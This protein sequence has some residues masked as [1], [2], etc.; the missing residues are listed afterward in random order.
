MKTYY[1]SAT[2][3]DGTCFD[4]RNETEAYIK[5]RE[6]FDTNEVELDMITEI[7]V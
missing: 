1:F 5:A 7:D 3:Q 4:C 2:G 6:Y